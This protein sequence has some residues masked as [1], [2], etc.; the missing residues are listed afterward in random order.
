[1]IDPLIRNGRGSEQYDALSIRQ[2]EDSDGER[3]NNE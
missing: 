1:M 3:E 2:E